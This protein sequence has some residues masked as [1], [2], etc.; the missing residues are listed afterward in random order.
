MAPRF[1]LGPIDFT[2]P[3]PALALL[4]LCLSLAAFWTPSGAQDIN[5]YLAKE[6]PIARAGLFA[7]IGGSGD[8]IGTKVAG[9]K[10]GLVIASPMKENPDYFY[11]WLRDGSLVLWIMDCSLLSRSDRL[12]AGLQTHHR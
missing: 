6:K 8:G 3:M 1:V 7:N 4:A 9:A 10:P 2:I 11:F 12:V 5:A